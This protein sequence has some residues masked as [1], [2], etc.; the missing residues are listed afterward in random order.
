V[1]AAKALVPTAVLLFAVVFAPNEPCP[2]ATLLA[3]V[4]FASKA[5]YQLL[6]Y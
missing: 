4:V 3:P 6:C 1:F 5:L 2:T